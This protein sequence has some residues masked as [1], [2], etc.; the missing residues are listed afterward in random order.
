[1]WVK[2]RNVE[3]GPLVQKTETLRER[4]GKHNRTNGK[5]GGAK[6]HSEEKESGQGDD[7]EKGEGSTKMKYV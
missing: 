6:E 4:G 3:R 5:S 2:A 7:G 1:M